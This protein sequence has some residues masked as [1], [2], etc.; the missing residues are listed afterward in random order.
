MDPGFWDRLL[1]QIRFF[2]RIGS[3][4]VFFETRV[5]ARMTPDKI[6]TRRHTHTQA[7]WPRDLG[8]GER[9]RG[10]ERRV[11]SRSHKTRHQALEDK[12]PHDHTH[13]QVCNPM[14]LA[15]QCIVVDVLKPCVAL[16]L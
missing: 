9:A 12:G 13:T 2:K 7:A 1:N 10:G 16:N 11:R 15:D 4:I 14:G 6:T 5:D 8:E 3:K